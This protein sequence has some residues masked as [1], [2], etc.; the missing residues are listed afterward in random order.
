MIISRRKLAQS[1]V[2]EIKNG[3]SAFAETEEVAQLIEN[4]LKTLNIKVHIDR[5]EKGSWFIPEKP[6]KK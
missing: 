3:Y 2:E 6:A 1:K 4:E 5:T